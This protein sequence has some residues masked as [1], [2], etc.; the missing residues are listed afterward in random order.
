MN[1]DEGMYGLS[2]CIFKG[3]GSRDKGY[4]VMTI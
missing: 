2:S 1:R 4:C 3:L